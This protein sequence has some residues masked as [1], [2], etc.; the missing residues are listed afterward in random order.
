M[1]VP[2]SRLHCTLCRERLDFFDGTKM[3]LKRFESAI[4]DI[5]AA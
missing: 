1:I 4:R 5:F 3:E 2:E